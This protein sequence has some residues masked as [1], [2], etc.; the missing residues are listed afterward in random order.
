MTSEPFFFFRFLFSRELTYF[1]FLLL[2]FFSTF[3][4]SIELLF[5][6]GYYCIKH[7]AFTATVA[8]SAFFHE[9]FLFFECRGNEVKSA[10]GS[11][12]CCVSC[13]A[14]KDPNGKE[15]NDVYEVLDVLFCLL[16]SFFFFFSFRWDFGRK[17]CRPSE[18]GFGFSVCVCVCVRVLDRSITI[19]PP[20]FYL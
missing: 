19:F 4:V 2:L 14:I 1:V 10:Y 3:R 20:F 7:A 5:H 9:A 15:K 8:A 12:V 6:Y 18:S 17:C 16:T 13:S 11:C